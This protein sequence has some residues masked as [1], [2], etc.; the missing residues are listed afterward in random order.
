MFLL[1]KALS[2]C[3]TAGVCHGDLKSQNVLIS[4]TNWLQITDFAPFKP[5]FLTQDNPSAFTFFFDTSRRQ[6]CYIA[7]ERFISANQYEKE[8]QQK[9]DEWLFGSLTPKMDMFSAGCIVFE[10]LCDRTPFT[11]SSLCEY[12]SMSETDASTLLSS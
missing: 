8:Y 10:L 12:R 1:F 11:Y 7:P 6:S 4:S 3:E 2:Q 9:G 5:C